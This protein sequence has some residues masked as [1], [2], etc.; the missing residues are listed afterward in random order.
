MCVHVCFS[1]GIKVYVHESDV[2][3]FI[4]VLQIIAAWAVGVGGG[5]VGSVI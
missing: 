1:L 4:S 3:D 2:A 5:G